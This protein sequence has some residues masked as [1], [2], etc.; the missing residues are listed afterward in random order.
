MALYASLFSYN[1][2]DILNFGTEEIENPR[3][4]LPIAGLCGLGLSAV[5]Y[6]AINV[7]YFSVL[8]VDEFKTTDT[9]VIIKKFFKNSKFLEWPLNLQ[10]RR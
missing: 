9:C 10:K 7:A 2:W 1:G 4:T 3:R 5:T 8:T 6:V